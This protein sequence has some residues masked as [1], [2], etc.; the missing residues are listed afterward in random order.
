MTYHEK[1][2]ELTRLWIK[3]RTNRQAAWDLPVR[4]SEQ[5]RRRTEK[6]HYWD[7]RVRE[8]KAELEGIDYAQSQQLATLQDENR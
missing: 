4:S 6:V 1:L 7:A 3:A 8:L 5:K 2:T